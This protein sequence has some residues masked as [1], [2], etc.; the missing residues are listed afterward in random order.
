MCGGGGLLAKSCLI[1]VTP[2]T[3]ARQACVKLL[4]IH[5]EDYI[6]KDEV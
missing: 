4:K 6:L 1:L 5:H 2:W 3:V